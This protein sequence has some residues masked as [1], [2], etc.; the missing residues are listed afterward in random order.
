ML[1]RHAR[2]FIFFVSVS[3]LFAAG[4]CQ[5]SGD[6]TRTT[7]ANNVTGNTQREIR[8]L[9]D[10]YVAALQLR[11][12]DALDRIWADE[13]TFVNLYGDLLNKQNRMD[14]IKS[15]ATAFKSIK[16]SEADVRMYGQA[17]V[18]TFQ[19]AIEAHYSGQES[20]GNYRVTTVWAQP[21]GTWQLVAVQ[22]TKMK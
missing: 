5:L 16:L 11:D 19:I 2:F 22:M 7:D 1:A 3:V 9:L 18:A 13:L 17:A 15:G 21:K 4:S 14:N 20:S 8:T 10:Q 6:N 12:L